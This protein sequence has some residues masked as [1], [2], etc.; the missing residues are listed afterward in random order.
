MKT[1]MKSNNFTL[2]AD[3]SGGELV[4]RYGDDLLFFKCFSLSLTHSCRSMSLLLLVKSSVLIVKDN[5]VR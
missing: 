4:A 1:W 3:F 5:F 2:L